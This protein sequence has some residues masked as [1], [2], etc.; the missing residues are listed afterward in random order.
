MLHDQLRYVGCLGDFSSL[1]LFVINKACIQCRTR[2]KLKSYKG[3]LPC[4]PHFMHQR[5]AR[6][7]SLR[8]SP[9]RVKHWRI[10]CSK[11][12]SI[13]LNDFNF[14][15]VLHCIH[16][17]LIIKRVKLKSHQDNQHNTVGCVPYIHY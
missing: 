15:L 3:I 9:T 2:I 11:Q 17:L 8:R 5:F 4:L 10:K 6:T 13:P 12:S 7:A 14:I 16:V 1:T